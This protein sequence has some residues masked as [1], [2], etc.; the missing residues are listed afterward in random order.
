VPPARR[1]DLADDAAFDDLLPLSLQLKSSVH[2]T[3]IDVA[4]HAARL[5]APLPGMSVLDVGAGVGKFCLAAALALPRASFVG[6]EWR[7]HLVSLAR[8]IASEAQQTNARFVAVDALDLDW[9]HY[10][11]FYFYNPFA[12]QLFDAE[13]ALDR[14]IELEAINF[15]RY[16]TAVRHRLAHARLGTRVV[17]YHGYGAPIPPGYELM[18]ADAIGSDRV[19]LW[20]KTRVIASCAES[21]R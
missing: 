4:R 8:R 11:A 7:P 13:L 2:F 5:L 12:E 18:H 16:A 21:S 1:V 20:I 9:S 19:E 17:T 10:D 15:V 3:P 6:A 14:T